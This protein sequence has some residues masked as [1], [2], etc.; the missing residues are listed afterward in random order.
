MKAGRH[1][2]M[3]EDASGWT[4]APVGSPDVPLRLVR[5][6]PTILLNVIKDRPT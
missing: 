3:G 6:L 4:P 1:Q 5:T 2:G